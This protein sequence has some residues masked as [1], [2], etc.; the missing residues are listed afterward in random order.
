MAWHGGA[1]AHGG[2]WGRGRHGEPMDPEAMGRRIDG[3]VQWML[4]D[5]DATDEQ[6]TRVA[7]IAKAAAAELAPLR[8][9][10]FDARKK[11]V[12]LLARPTI[13][14]AQIERVRV[15][16]MQLGDQVTKRMTQALLDAADVLSP[17]QRVKL[18]ERW[19]QRRG[20]HHR[21]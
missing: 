17:Q 7:Q 2:R 12:E 13:D 3:M 5:I 9:Q 11:T 15:E 8:A 20:R 21:G 6:R 18:A 14:R 1:H 16:Q 19:E 4:A 10:H